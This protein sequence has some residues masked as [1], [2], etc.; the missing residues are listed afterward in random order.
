MI[1]RSVSLPRVAGW[2]A[3]GRVAGVK[4]AYLAGATLAAQGNP[5][6]DIVVPYWSGKPGERKEPAAAMY[7]AAMRQGWQEA[8]GKRGAGL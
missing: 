6:P 4:A 8:A 3:L 5:C 1:R 2:Q 7:L